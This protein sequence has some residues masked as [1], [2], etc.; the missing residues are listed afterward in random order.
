[1]DP[2]DDP[3]DVALAF[4]HAGREVGNDRKPLVGVTGT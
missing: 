4:D 1:M 3:F 2:F